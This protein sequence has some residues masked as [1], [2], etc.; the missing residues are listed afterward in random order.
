MKHVLGIRDNYNLYVTL[1]CYGSS[2]RVSGMKSTFVS[3][4]LTS[5]YNT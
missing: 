2:G 3:M 1:K 5:F 4:I